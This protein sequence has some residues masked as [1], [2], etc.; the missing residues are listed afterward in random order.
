MSFMMWF[1][2]VCFQKHIEVLYAFNLREGC[3]KL[4]ESTFTLDASYYSFINIL[5][6]IR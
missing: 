2:E 5:T 4:G 1:L 6:N 3:D